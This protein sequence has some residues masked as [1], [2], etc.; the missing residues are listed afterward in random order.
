[1]QRFKFVNWWIRGFVFWCHKQV[2]LYT[3]TSL[4]HQTTNPDFF[5][6][7]CHWF[8][9]AQNEFRLRIVNLMVYFYEKREF[10]TFPKSTRSFSWKKFMI[11][12]SM[13]IKYISHLLLCIYSCHLEFCK[14][15]L[16]FSNMNAYK[17]RLSIE[18][19]GC[20]KVKWVNY[21][22]FWNNLW[23]GLF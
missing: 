17:Q 6:E 8:W 16:S 4:W 7:I 18:L 19:Q 20:L 9:S 14:G 22:T 13:L 21:R 23:C 11:H 3:S 5:Y 10:L 2:I 15:I 1:M 12:F